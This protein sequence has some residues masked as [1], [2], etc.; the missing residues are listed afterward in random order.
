MSESEKLMTIL[1]T[2]QQEEITDLKHRMNALESRFD[3]MEV[4]YNFI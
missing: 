2:K 4:S 3:S 1:L